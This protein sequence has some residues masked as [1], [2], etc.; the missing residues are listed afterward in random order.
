VRRARSVQRPH[1][2]RHDPN[3]ATG[4]PGAASQNATDDRPPADRRNPDTLTAADRPAARAERIATAYGL[5]QTNWSWRNY[6]HQY[7]RMTA[8]AGGALAR[9]L[10]ANPP[11]QDQ[12]VGVAAEKRTNRST[13]IAADSTA[14]NATT[15]RVIVVYEELPGGAGVTDITPRHT[16]YRATVTKISGAWKVT[17]WSLLP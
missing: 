15:A 5:A 4:A 2:R 9:D 11:E 10:K 14:I 12:L 13:A 7:R 16:V 6:A 1:A 3:S 17:A 8:L